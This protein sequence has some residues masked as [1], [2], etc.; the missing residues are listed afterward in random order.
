MSEAQFTLPRGMKDIDP[1]EMARR[2]WLTDKIR[3]VL[4]NYGFQMLEPSPVESLETLEAKSGPTIRDEIYWFKDKAERNLGLRFDLTVGMTRMIANRFDLPEP[5][6]ISSIGG[7]WRYDEPQFA[8]YRYFTQ[9]D[10]EIY[11]VADPSAD[12]EIIALS[13]DILESVGL[14]DHLVKISN[15]K[16]I[17]GFLRGLGIQSQ[18]DLDHMI[19]IIDKMGKIG[20]EQA[21]REFTRAGLSKDKVKRILG[22][23]DMGGDPDKVLEELE[24]KLPKGDMIHQGF[25]ELS[26]TIDRVE[27]L[28]KK[29]RIKI[30]LGIVRGISYY[31]GT[32]FEAYDSE[33][34]DVGAVLG[35]GRF[36]KLCKIYGKRD[37]PA[38]GVAGGYERLMLSLERKDLFPDIQQN[39]QVFV[40]TV[41]ETVWNEAVKIAQQLRNQGI[42]ADYDLKQRPLSKQ[43]EY[44][45]AL[46]VRISLVLGPREIKEV[47]VRLKDMKTGQEKTV[48]LSSVVDEIEKALA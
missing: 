12:A 18:N 30:D 21:E 17:E 13:S 40:A 29:N 8:R 34:E 42:R 31:D 43:L 41:N 38:T 24:S 2:I 14:K 26:R 5:I 4:W 28:G 19:R 36:D 32:V 44:A 10:A 23:A 6:K 15:R 1:E 46:K 39:P 37:M 11:G 9:W 35:G 25:K 3:Q 27:S 33:G 48:R 45:D 16:L 47:S 22:F 7:V 20:S